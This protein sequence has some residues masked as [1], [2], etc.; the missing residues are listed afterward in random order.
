MS[1][2]STV[3]EF[4]IEKLVKL[5]GLLGF[6]E[7][8][9]R[10][11]LTRGLES[12]RRRGRRAKVTAVHVGYAHKTCGRC[13][14]V[15][16]KAAKQCASCGARL[17]WRGWQVLGRIGILMPN[18]VSVSTLLAAVLFVIYGRM[19]LGDIEGNFFSFSGRDLVTFGAH[20]RVAVQAGEWWRLGTAVFLHAGIMHIGFNIFAL[21]VIGPQ[22]EQLFGRLRMFTFFVLTGVLAN[23]AVQI[24]SGWLDPL[25]LSGGLGGPLG[26]LAEQLWLPPLAQSIGA[27]GGVMGLIGVTAGWGHRDGTAVGRGAR[28]LMLQWL[29]YTTIFGLVVGANHGA[30]FAGFILGA[31]FGYSLQPVYRTRSAPGPLTIAGTVL[32]LLITVVCVTMTLA[33]K[34]TQALWQQ[35]FIATP[36]L[37]AAEV[38]LADHYG[39]PHDQLLALRQVTGHSWSTVSPAAPARPTPGS[40][41]DNHSG[42]GASDGPPGPMTG[43][44]ST[45]SCTTP[46][47]PSISDCGLTQQQQQALTRFLASY[48]LTA[49]FQHEMVDTGSRAARK[50]W[51]VLAISSDNPW[52]LLRFVGTDASNYGY[53]TE[54][55]IARLR[56]WDRTFRLQVAAAGADWVELRLVTMPP[57]LAAWVRELVAFCPDLL[58]TGDVHLPASGELVDI[59]RYIRQHRR[60]Q[61]WWD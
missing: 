14:A 49:Y 60:I 59:E 16:D 43:I 29:L 33:P 38:R 27:S 1:D 31:A 30:H 5:G 10:W 18:I 42:D 17:G 40:T 56:A 45:L 41:S 39:I 8:R 55:I 12:I 61:L 50:Q 20:V 48:G 23:V 37:S 52:D 6:N 11:K 32:S 7:I 54:E 25:M 22:V 2:K 9:L 46:N 51:F 34:P 58:K 21:S 36:T 44:R 47:A 4:V 53:R 26:W 28:N 19:L 35:L 57:D 24:V 3:T 13:G 15:N